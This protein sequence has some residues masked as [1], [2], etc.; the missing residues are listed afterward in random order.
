MQGWR[1]VMKVGWLGGLLAMTLTAQA[2]E[3]PGWPTER[4]AQE[5]QALAEQVRRWDTAYHDE[6]W[7]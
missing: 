4:L 6:G 2:E 7:R 5:S 3:C 1:W